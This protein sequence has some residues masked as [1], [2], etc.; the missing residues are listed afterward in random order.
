[1]ILDAHAY[2]AYEAAPYLRNA[3]DEALK[4]RHESIC[5]NLW[6]PN[7]SGE[8]EL[9]HDA[10]ERAYW[11]KRLTGVRSEMH[12]R[13]QLSEVGYDEATLL[14]G[15]TLPS[16][17]IKAIDGLKL[18][19]KK[20]LVRFSSAQYTRDALERGSFLIKPAGT[21]KTDSSLN[22]AQADDELSHF[23]VTA[24]RKLKMQLHGYLPGEDPSQARPIHHTPLE[25]FHY[26]N[27]SNFY[28]L[29]MADAFNPRMFV[30]FKADAALII[31]DPNEFSRRIGRAFL[32]Q[33][34]GSIPKEA[35]VSYYDP[36]T[37]QRENLKP[38]FSKNFSYA[39][40]DEYRMLWWPGPTASPLTPIS[41][42]A[43]DLSDIAHAVYI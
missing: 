26:M 13:G 5:G 15:N 17:I 3:H 8:A 30:D 14:A 6:E 36:Y 42:E 40:Q 23:A 34:P 35:S 38:G 43:G 28:V 29:C 22:A 2:A 24:E 18:P 11:T 9:R 39:Y 20:F 27:T 1:M 16:T 10:G 19:R 25:M 32:R 12:R 37:I 31:K 41:V 4:K 21:Y 7:S 33:L